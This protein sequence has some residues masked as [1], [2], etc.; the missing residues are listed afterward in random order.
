MHLKRKSTVAMVGLAVAIILFF[1]VTIVSAASGT[2]KVKSQELQLVFDGKTLVLPQG[3]YIF[4]VKGTNYVPLRFFSYA[5]KKN[6]QWNADT[7][8]VM[9]TEPTSLELLLL[10]EYLMNAIGMEGKAAAK[11]GVNVSVTPIQAKFNFEGETKPIPSGQSAYSFNGSIYVP[12]RFMSESVG[13]Q[14]QWDGK[15]GR[16]IAESPAF[17]PANDG[18]HTGHDGDHGASTGDGHTGTGTAGGGAGSGGSGGGALPGT[19]AGGGAAPMTY[20]AITTSAESRLQSL[21]T[22][23]QNQL[24]PLGMD[25]IRGDSGKTQQQL[26]DEING[27]INQCTTQFNQIVNEAERQLTANGHSTAI[28]AEYRQAFEDQMNEGKQM[29]KDLA[30]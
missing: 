4:A 19:G 6:V 20:E 25:L 3:Q 2:V 13:I 15:A 24:L 12:V 30:G 18:A 8:T 11:G 16:V 1:H 27:V 26:I 14:I 23:C 28:I 22:D 5:L 21:K 17:E 29:L 9:V 7:S 10:N